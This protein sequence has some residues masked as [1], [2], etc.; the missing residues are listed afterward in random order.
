[1]TKF[2]ILVHY[3]TFII[4][5]GVDKIRIFCLLNYLDDFYDI[6]CV[7]LKQFQIVPCH[8]DTILATGHLSDDVVGL[9]VM[10]L[11]VTSDA[12]Y[13]PDRKILN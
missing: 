12:F 7:I 2:V 10:L 6:N 3:A 9:A 5:K 8:Y 4:G 13:V 1:M 11:A